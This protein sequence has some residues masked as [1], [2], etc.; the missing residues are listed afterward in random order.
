ML[1]SALLTEDETG[2]KES[3]IITAVSR[4]DGS[5]TVQNDSPIDGLVEFLGVLSSKPPERHGNECPAQ[6][7]PE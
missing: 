1:T 6:H 7:C 4:R 2:N 3:S 5:D